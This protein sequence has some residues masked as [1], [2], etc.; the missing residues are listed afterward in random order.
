M[1]LWALFGTI[2]MGCQHFLDTATSI[3]SWAV[4]HSSVF[5]LCI[6][7]GLRSE[8]SQSCAQCAVP[9][10]RAVPNGRASC[11]EA[12]SCAVKLAG[13]RVVHSRVCSKASLSSQS[14]NPELVSDSAFKAQ[15]HLKCLE[16]T[17]H[18]AIAHSPWH[19][20]CHLRVLCT[21]PL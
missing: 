5:E 1:C 7:A 14:E 2:T 9:Q 6:S 11:A 15:H 3:I 18:R 4:L 12:Q 20:Y 8:T 19:T 16:S 21:L 13:L 17:F 10:S